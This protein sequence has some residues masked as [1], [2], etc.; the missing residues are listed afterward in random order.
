MGRKFLSFFGAFILLMAVVA[1]IPPPASSI[2]SDAGQVV[3]EVA[4]PGTPHVLNGRVYAVNQVG[5]TIILGGDFTRARNDNST[6]ELVRNGLLAFDA[7]TGQ[8][9]PGFNPNP[10]GADVRV[11]LPSG[12]GTSVYV[13][14]GFTSIGGVSRQRLARVR[15]SDGAVISGF[16]AGAITGLVRDLALRNGRLWVAGAFTHVGGRG[17]TALTTVDPTTGASQNYMSLPVEGQHNGGATQVLKMDISPDG[18]R[19]AAVGNFLTVGG[20]DNDQFMMLDI[21]GGAAQL[22]NWQTNFYTSTCA[23]VFNTYMRD[24]DISPDGKFLVAVTTGAY[25]GADSACDTSARFE[26]DA[27]GSNIQPSWVD[28]TGGDTTY[29]VEI[30]P[31]AVY[32]GGH[33]R[34]QNNPFAGDRVGPGAV[35]REGIAALDPINGLPLSWNPGRAKGVGVFDFLY[36]DQGLWVASDTD[37]IGDFQYK[38]RIARLPRNGATYPAVRTPSLPNNVYTGGPRGDSSDPSVLYRVNAGGPALQAATGPDWS[39]DTN[40]SPS[41]FVNGG[42]NR[43]GWG[44]VPFVNGSVPAGTPRQV[45][46]SELWDPGSAPETEWDFPVASGTPL[47]VRLYF[48]NRCTCTQQAGQRVFDVDL[49]GTRILD[50][51]DLVAMNGHDTGAMGEF[52]I[53]SDGNVDIDLSHVTEN[54][55]INAIEIIR[56]DVAPPASGGLSRRAY[57][58]SSVGGST[59]VPD[60]GIDWNTITGAFMINGQ[61]YL[62]HADGNFTKQ[63]FDGSSYG[64]AFS[65]DTSD[66]LQRLDDWHADISAATGMWFDSGRIYFTRG[67]SNQLFYRYFSPESDVVGA[68]R[69]VA[70]NSGPGIDFSTVRGMFGTSSR[71]FWASANGDLH[72]ADW[73]HNGASGAP[74]P[75][76][77]TVTSGPAADGVEWSA[78][79]LFLFQDEN[80]D[81]AGVPSQPTADFTSDCTGRDCTFDASTST[82]PGSS[83]T[84]YDWDFG[85][86]TTGAGETANRLYTADGTFTVTLTVTTANGGSA[87]TSEQVSVAAGNT[88]P[89]A[90]FTASCTDLVCDFDGSGSSDPE[91]AVSWAWDFG[92]GQNGTGETVSHPYG[93]AGP[94]TVTLTVTDGGGLTDSTTRQVNP[95]TGGTG[96]GVVSFVGSSNSNQNTNSA[97][98]SVPGGVQVGDTLVLTSALNNTTVTIGNPAGWTVLDSLSGSGV[99]ARS[100]TR[101]ATAADAGDQVTVN[102]SG[103]AKTDLSLSVYR[104]VGGGST[105]VVANAGALDL[106]NSADHTAPPVTVPGGSGAWVSTYFA[107]K[108]SADVTWQAPS[109]TA[110]RQSASG[111]GGGAMTTILVDSDGPVAAGLVPGRTGT[112]TP[113]VS[114]TAMFTIAVGI[115]GTGGGGNTPPTAAFTSSCT[116]LVCEFDGSGSTDAEGGVSWAWD[117]GDGQSGTG[118]MVTHPYGSAGPRTVT[119]TV[120]DDGG[121]SDSTTRQA[122]PTNGGTG[123]GVVSFVGSS[124]SNQNT[125]SPSVSVPGGAQAGDTLV[126]TMALNNPDVTIGALPGWT[127]LDSLAGSGVQARSWTRSATAGDA[128]GEVAVSVSGYAKTDMSLSAYRAVGGGSTS[129]VANAGALDLTSSA[130]HTAPPV[131]VPGGS[132][133]WVSTYFAGKSSADVTWQAPSGTATRQ[134]AAGAGGGAMTTILVDSDGPVSSG[135]VPGRTGTTT[136]DVS[137]TAMFTIAVGVG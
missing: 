133:A 14:G 92:D 68:K 130:N 118:A 34:W 103:Y 98:V 35:S 17:Q 67:G 13:G 78:H 77:A 74:V 11:V 20:A 59:T 97:S 72:R 105:S 53:V 57:S 102:L 41:P 36:T 100:W 45:F 109:G 1:L 52:E 113:N 131:T 46:D 70:A 135:L 25:R 95:T 79:A 5:N 12:D 112:T 104:A 125:N 60:G 55:L 116:D 65:V 44:P 33:A 75:G 7:T 23:S 32:T 134:S 2:D 123:T 87:T 6:T 127:A 15:V 19:L 56:S 136:P 64:T 10:S 90:A 121:L 110:T 93:S 49:D 4:A 28:T 108:S 99:Q 137:R 3:S 30:T 37:R 22:A 40:A 38:G 27:T 26:M 83:I 96:T 73:V 111:V 128:G 82:A 63:T 124:N 85:D 132:N 94:R 120:T 24:V 89:T 114:R 91:G 8:I 31:S 88:A 101:P 119:L 9:L 80:G 51:L 18:S 47:K 76:T 58:D 81:D 71:L 21:G 39:A 42:H 129:V 43:A 107:G 29:S 66:E 86:G 84:S 69:F 62:G 48:A 54:P 106:T 122:N 16:N 61:I 115:E 50:D 126:L 117:F